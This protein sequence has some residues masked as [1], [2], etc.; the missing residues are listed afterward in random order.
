MVLSF[1][2]I[3]RFL[4]K[5]LRKWTTNDSDLQVFS[6]TVDT[7]NEPR[8]DSCEE[9]SSCTHQVECHPKVG[10]IVKLERFTH[11]KNVW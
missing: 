7:M 10:N 1:T 8:I 2:S 5:K 9:L 6:A 11:L 3:L 4:S